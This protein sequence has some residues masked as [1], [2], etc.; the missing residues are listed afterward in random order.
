MSVRL[1]D[2]DQR[3]PWGELLAREAARSLSRAEERLGLKLDAA[4][5]VVSIAPVSA[6]YEALGRRPHDLAAVALPGQNRVIIN[7]TVYLRSTAPER[8]S[9]LIHEFA[10][11]LLGRGVPGVL[12]RW[13]DEG[14]AMVAAE[15]TSFVFHARLVVAATVG[16]LIPI[17]QLGHWAAPG[18]LDEELAYAQSYALTRFFLERSGGSTEQPAPVVRRLAHPEQGRALRELLADP[19][20]H[21]A[22]ERAWKESVQTFWTWVAA[23]SGGGALWGFATGLFLIAY[24]RKRRMA[25][26]I[27]ERWGEEEQGPAPPA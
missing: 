23:L 14:L 22:L 26:R 9:I 20:Y 2:E 3:G 12:P 4:P 17:A 19:G 11:L 16:R 15:E 25:R 18:G 24:W 10:H 6:F 8:Q 13:L 1:S 21:R 5:F 27:E 7:R